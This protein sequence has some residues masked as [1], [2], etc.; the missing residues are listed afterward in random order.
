MV[1]VESIFSLFLV[2]VYSMEKGILFSI[3]GLIMVISLVFLIVTSKNKS[4]I[5]TLKF[6]LLICVFYI[7]LV[8]MCL[9]TGKMIIN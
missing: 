3:G 4:S 9:L 2:G 8:S 1:S 5:F 7:M 6:G